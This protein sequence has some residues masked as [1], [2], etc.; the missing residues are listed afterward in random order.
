MWNDT[1]GATLAERGRLATSWWSRGRGLLGT[2]SLPPGEGLLISPCNSIHSFFMQYPFDAIFIDKQGTAVHLIHA[3]K[4]SRLSRIVFAAHS[5]LEL[6]AGTIGT[7]G[8]QLGDK[9]RWDG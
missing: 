5:V 9:I 4:P 2:K 1:R 8:T 3:M 7:T 6:P